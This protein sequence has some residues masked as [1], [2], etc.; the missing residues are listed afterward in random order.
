MDCRSRESQ[1]RVARASPKAATFAVADIV[2]AATRSRMMSS[3]G[4][5]NTG[6]ELR[7]RQ[8]LHRAGLRFRLNCSSLPGTP[9]LVLPKYRTVIFV[10]G[11][12]WHRHAG[13]RFAYTPATRRAF[14][15]IKF[16]T[17]KARDRAKAAVLRGRGW[18]VLTIWECESADEA[19][20]DR[21]FWRVLAGLPHTQ[22]G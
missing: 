4:R 20:L 17:N 15:D 8:Y 16:S 7:V 13:C 3:I 22:A 21:L 9:D 2:D 14:W 5:K 1:S 10:H 12:F 19:S 18:R 11:C 6:P